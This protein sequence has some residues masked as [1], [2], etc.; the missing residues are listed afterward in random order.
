[1]E[2]QKQKE[3]D[4]VKE[5]GEGEAREKSVI[6]NSNSTGSNVSELTEIDAKESDTPT[7]TTAPT[8]ISAAESVRAN[9]CAPSTR[10]HS[11]SHEVEM[12]VN[13][14]APLQVPSS[15]PSRSPDSA[16]DTAPFIPR[17]SNT[18]VVDGVL[19]IS[20]IPTHVANSGIPNFVSPN[21][22]N[23]QQHNLNGLRVNHSHD[24]NR[25][26]ELPDTDM[27]PVPHHMVV[28]SQGLHAFTPAGR[29][30][31]M[32]TPSGHYPY[33]GNA[34]QPSISSDRYHS[35][36]GEYRTPSFRKA[37]R[38]VDPPRGYS[39]PSVNGNGN[40][41]VNGDYYR[42][43]RNGDRAASPTQSNC[44]CADCDNEGCDIEGCEECNKQNPN[45]HHQVPHAQQQASYWPPQAPHSTFRNND[46]DFQQG[47]H[48][49]SYPPPP[50]P[51]RVFNDRMNMGMGMGMGMDV[52]HRP[53]A[54]SS[55]MAAA[56][57]ERAARVKLESAREAYEYDHPSRGVRF[58]VSYDRGN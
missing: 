11:V 29:E 16:A 57:N 26:H 10:A 25:R 7:A 56:R 51:P 6:S 1:M 41:Y 24:H 15:S 28:P 33:A 48:G 39:P 12:D 27:A 46:P 55:R 31:R 3:I 13:P 58:P 37:Y 40:L 44:S 36:A 5:E 32:V 21:A 53:R 52:D 54:E 38:A 2:K 42:T 20:A 17:S 19:Q 22:N 35:P 45:L 50:P 4:Q 8:S 34:I 43:S 49:Y 47:F 18:R 23:P 9:S 30:I 14:F